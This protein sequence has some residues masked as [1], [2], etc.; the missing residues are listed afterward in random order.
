MW[1]GKTM[2]VMVGVIITINLAL[3]EN[4]DLTSTT[5][6]SFMESTTTTTTAAAFGSG[7]GGMTRCFDDAQC[8]RCMLAINA[9]PGFPHTLAEYNNMNRS[10]MQL[11]DLRFFHMLVSTVSCWTNV[12]PPRILFP[13]LQE[14]DDTG[15]CDSAFGMYFDGCMIAEYVNPQLMH[16]QYDTY[17]L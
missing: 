12:T 13:A 10:A 16:A 1:A 3:G 7:C 2:V 6:M 4:T 5:T 17:S 9:T 8:A 14:L 11:T 15:A